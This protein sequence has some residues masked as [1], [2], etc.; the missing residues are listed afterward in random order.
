MF[1]FEEGVWGTVVFL[2]EE[3][4]GLLPAVKL[5]VVLVVNQ[6]VVGVVEMMVVEVEME[7]GNGQGSKG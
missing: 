4:V 2:F 3:V 6:E 1:L 5:M 7:W